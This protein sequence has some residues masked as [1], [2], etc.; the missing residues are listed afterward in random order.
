MEI[1]KVLTESHHLFLTLLILLELIVVVLIGIVI[2]V[3]RSRRLS[4]QKKRQ[5]YKNHWMECLVDLSLGFDFPKE[6]LAK[7]SS[8]RLKKEFRDCIII[9]AQSLSPKARPALVSL[10]KE[11]GYLKIDH[12]ALNSF[13]FAKRLRAMAR[14]ETIQDDSSLPLLEKLIT[15][16][17]FYIRFSAIKFIVR[18]NSNHIP[19]LEQALQSVMDEKR[20]DSLLEILITLASYQREFF[21][22]SF[23]K[24][25][26]NEIKKIYLKVI[27]SFKVSECLPA[28]R[29]S[30]NKMI[31]N[32]EDDTL[33]FKSHLLCLT[34]EPDIESEKLLDSLR[35]HKKLEIR[36]L[37]M[38]SLLVIRPELKEELFQSLNKEEVVGLQ[39]AF[40][41]FAINMGAGAYG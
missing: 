19:A 18:K 11:L 5:S 31:R 8:R 30:L 39:E 1:L 4:L 16:R 32:D 36:F 41:N 6:T 23:R 2:R 22:N 25:Q 33:F 13:S 38:C 17:N 7:I 15:D 21:V 3:E 34:I 9:V 12:K 26:K 10:Y 35:Q 27:H 40:E 29:E 24:V 20:K 14:I 37:A 28:V